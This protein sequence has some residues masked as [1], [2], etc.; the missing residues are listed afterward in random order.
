MKVEFR[1]SAMMA[2]FATMAMYDA[3]DCY[4]D[5][6]IDP[7]GISTLVNSA[8][9]KI[10]LDWK[11]QTLTYDGSRNAPWEG[12]LNSIGTVFI[13]AGIIIKGYKD[14]EL[15]IGGI[16]SISVLEPAPEYRH[17]LPIASHLANEEWWRRS[18][19]KDWETV[20]NYSVSADAPAL[21]YDEHPDEAYRA[22]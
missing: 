5:V 15:E 17:I 16:H 18:Y 11:R 20:S 6:T 2:S 10:E 4:V 8:G 21:P 13:E 22:I 1:L 3:E 14:I 19:H 7:T 9:N 12:Y